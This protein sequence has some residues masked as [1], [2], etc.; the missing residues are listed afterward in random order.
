LLLSNYL[1]DNHRSFFVDVSIS[2]HE[3]KNRGRK[4]IRGRIENKN[5][6]TNDP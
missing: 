4:N 6:E 2:D 1:E 5:D 3:A